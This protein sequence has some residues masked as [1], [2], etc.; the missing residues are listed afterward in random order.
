[1][2][3]KKSRS[4]PS[5]WLDDAAEAPRAEM[6]ANRDRTKT[7]RRYRLYIRAAVVLF[8][9]ALIA[10]IILVGSSLRPVVDVGNETLAATPGKAAAILAMESWLN[11]DP[12]PLPAPARVLSWDGFEIVERPTQNEQEAQRNPLPDWNLE[13][14]EFSVSDGQGVLYDATVQVAVG[15]SVGATALSTPTVLPRPLADANALSGAKPWYG[16]AQGSVPQPVTTAINAWAVAYTG[17]NPDALRLAVQDD[18]G[19]RNYVPLYNVAAFTV[20]S[21]EAAA[22]AEADPEAA[23]TRMLVQ[24][25]LAV[26]W[27]AQGALEPGVRVPAITYD[28]LILR[29]N[30]AAPVVVAWGAAGTG[31]TLKAFSNAISGRA[32]PAVPVTRAP[33]P[34]VIPEPIETPTPEVAPI[35]EEGQE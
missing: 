21:G 5:N 22:L 35:E 16:L 13:I 25:K 8:P 6:V 29:A 30:T 20:A 19:T 28:L 1:M 31:P 4:G 9:L 3:F 2:A 23:P 15:A 33:D 7:Q 10:V 32:I 12:T 11:S 27:T 24:V 34:V 17:G 26:Q 14:H 18:D